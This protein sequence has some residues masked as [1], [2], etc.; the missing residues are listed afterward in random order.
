MA[1]KQDAAVALRPDGGE[2]VCLLPGLVV[3]DLDPRASAF[4]PAREIVDDPEI[5][6]ARYR[7]VGHQ[8]AQQ[9]D[10]VVQFAHRSILCD[11]P[12]GSGQKT[13]GGLE[14]PI[15]ID[16]DGA[17]PQRSIRNRGVWRKVTPGCRATVSHIRRAF[18]WAGNGAR[19]R[20]RIKPPGLW[21]NGQVVHIK[22]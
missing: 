3:K 2:Y 8:F 9:L 14:S 13:S 15:T 20:F 21:V 16:A 18:S 10:A 1:R 22:R 5:A 12:P 11:M 17:R 6:A 19:K 7:R 4:E